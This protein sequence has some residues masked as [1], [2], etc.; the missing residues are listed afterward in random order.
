MSDT[1]ASTLDVVARSLGEYSLGSLSLKMYQNHITHT[2]LHHTVPIV[3]G[4]QLAMLGP[5]TT[6]CSGKW[7]A[8]RRRSLE[9]EEEILTIVAKGP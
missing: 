7:L 2:Y 6:T 1:T 5:P 4:S 8:R 9:D 3:L